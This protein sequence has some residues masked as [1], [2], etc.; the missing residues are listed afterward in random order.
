MT[1]L[2]RASEAGLSGPAAERLET[3]LLA[4]EA[5]V[6]EACEARTFVGSVCALAIVYVWQLDLPRATGLYVLTELAR[7]AIFESQGEQGLWLLWSPADWDHSDILSRPR[8]VD[9]TDVEGLASD[10]IAAGCADPEGAFVCELAYRLVRRDWSAVMPLTPDF[11][12][13]AM[14]HDLSPD[15]FDTFRVTAPEA[16]VTA[17]DARS[18]LRFPDH[19]NLS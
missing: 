16:A 12:G 14:E 2:P 6:R 15:V 19:Y 7:D 1:P 10:L 5:R 13:W 9:H 4:D 3:H 18:W 17:Y 11:A 8:T